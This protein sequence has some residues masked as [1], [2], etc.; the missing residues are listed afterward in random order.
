MERKRLSEQVRDY[1]ESTRLAPDALARLRST[2]REQRPPRAFTRRR[3]LFAAGFAG[4]VLASLFLLHVARAFDVARTIAREVARGHNQQLAVELRV[5]DFRDLRAAME[6]LEF[7]PV[8]PS[9]FREVD[10]KV[11]GARYTSLQGQPAAL[12]RLLDPKGEPCSLF[13]ARPE[14]RLESVWQSTHQIDGLLVDVWK[15][16]GLVMALARPLD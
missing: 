9:R 15:E 10:M 7:T 11:V 12:I 14:G 13:E 8:E 1:Y 6:K 16:K 3:M 5:H 4:I 2:I